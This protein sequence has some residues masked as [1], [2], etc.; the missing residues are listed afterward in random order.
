MS[1][2]V[3]S[4]IENEYVYITAKKKR[5]KVM[6]LSHAFLNRAVPFCIIGVFLRDNEQRG[7]HSNCKGLN[8]A[9]LLDVTNN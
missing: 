3:T 9:I 7:Y 8:K 1:F 4:N 2:T 6:F 5:K